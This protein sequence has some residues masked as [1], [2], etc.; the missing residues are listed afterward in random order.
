M[1][2]EAQVTVEVTLTGA[3]PEEIKSQNL[4]DLID[5]AVGR[6]INAMRW[7]TFDVE[8]STRQV[9]GASIIRR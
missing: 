7:P 8:V 1:A 9:G 2:A 3:I 4:K 5:E 6:G